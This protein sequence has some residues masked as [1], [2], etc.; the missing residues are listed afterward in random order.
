MR[1][2]A[3]P[4]SLLLVAAL[5][6]AGL[7]PTPAPAAT[8]DGVCGF[9][10]ARVPYSARAGGPAWRVYVRG[11][12]SCRAATEALAAIMH[13]RGRDHFNGDEANSYIAYRN[14]KCPY[15]QMGSQ[16][17][18]T[19]SPARPQARAVALRCSEVRCPSAGPPAYLSQSH[20]VPM[21]SL[22]GYP[23]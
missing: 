10:H 1:T 2:P 6:L 7:S 13:L 12:T 5:A 9:L 20:P 11:H 14:W 23:G 3:C 21:T 16:F 4:R 8:G 19:G 17:C 18:F 15:G 22:S